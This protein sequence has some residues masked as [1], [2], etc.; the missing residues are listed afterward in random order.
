MSQYGFPKSVRLLKPAE[1][2]YVFEQRCSKVDSLIVV[3]AAY[4]TSSRP[5][6]GMAVSR[7]FG[8]AVIRNRWKRSLREAF[9]RVQNELPRNLDLV[10]LPRRGASP[11][12]IR[13]QSSLKKL[14]ACN[15]SK[16]SQKQPPLENPS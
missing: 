10:V 9:R 3:Y 11:D 5:R 16:L 8:N 13:L 14:A 7:K 12:T 2:S 6:L 15:A 4:G 1:F